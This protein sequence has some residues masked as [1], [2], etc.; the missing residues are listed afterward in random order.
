MV[1]QSAEFKKAIDDSKK[2]SK[3]PSNDELLEVRPT[4]S[5]LRRTAVV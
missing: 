3:T 5:R 4:C 2:L 1:A